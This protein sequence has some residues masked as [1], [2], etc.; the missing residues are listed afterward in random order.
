MEHL[1]P[2]AVDATVDETLNEIQ[3]VRLVA[4]RR[5]RTLAGPYGSLRRLTKESLGQ[6][7]KEKHKLDSKQI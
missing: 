6:D 2:T 5:S 7:Y 3:E 4:Y 1:Q